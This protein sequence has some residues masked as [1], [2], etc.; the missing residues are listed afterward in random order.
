MNNALFSFLR[1]PLA[2]ALCAVCVAPA[3]AQTQVSEAWV[4]ATVAQQKATGAFMQIT[5]VGGAKLLAASSPVAGV[6][7]IH[8][9]KLVGDV[10]KMS[11]IPALD[12][13]AGKAVAL[14]PGGYHIMLMDL[15]QPI[16]AGQS[17]PITLSVQGADGKKQSIEVQASAK[18]M[19]GMPA[20]MAASMASAPMHH[21]PGAMMH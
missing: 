13:P 1:K 5:S 21:Q 12:L 17:V 3:W 16:Q 18:M 15:K 20:G 11:A 7:E 8:E 4:R 14:R 9:M 6:V 19:G 2:L 10:M